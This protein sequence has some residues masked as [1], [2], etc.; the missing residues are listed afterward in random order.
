MTAL[1]CS[2]IFFVY[3]SVGFN[4][5]YILF[6]NLYSIATHSLLLITSITLITLK[7]TKFEYKTIWKEGICFAVI[8]AYV[9]LEIYGLKIESDPMYFMPG[10]DVMEIL[11]LG[12]SAYLVV[13]ILFI[14]IYFNIFY[15]IDDRKFVFKK[16]NKKEKDFKIIERVL[17]DKAFK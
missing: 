3:P 4:N 10:N 14:A 11:G 8:L 2:L 13:Y 17:N 1:L 7:F 12:Y 9:F 16:F 6:E 15:L 5:K